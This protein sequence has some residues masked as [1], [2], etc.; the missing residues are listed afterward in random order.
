MFEKNEG[1][2]RGSNECAEARRWY[3][4]EVVGFAKFSR[5]DA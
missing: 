3:G 5:M 2:S 4:F 1:G